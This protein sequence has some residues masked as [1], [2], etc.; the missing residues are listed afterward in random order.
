MKVW[1]V[2]L[3]TLVWMWYLWVAYPD[4]VIQQVPIHFNVETSIPE[5][6]LN[7][8]VP[9][10]RVYDIGIQLVVPE[11]VYNHEIGTFGVQ[12]DLLDSSSNS[13]Q[14]G[15]TTWLTNYQSYWIQLARDLMLIIPYTLGWMRP[16]QILNNVIIPDYMHISNPIYLKA[17]IKLAKGQ[18]NALRLYSSYIVFSQ[19][20]Y[21][22]T[23]TMLYFALA[24]G[25]VLTGV[26]MAF[27][28]VRKWF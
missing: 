9:P 28:S 15:I 19:H 17:F 18:E 4:R 7:V 21:S 5:A 2:T 22:W 8:D 23:Q 3:I 25:F 16:E 11:T 1:V 10:Y 26:T 14:S 24:L 12:L 13:F 6:Y 27:K 20:P